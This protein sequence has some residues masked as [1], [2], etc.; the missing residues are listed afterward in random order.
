MHKGKSLVT[1]HK[2]HI[3]LIMSSFPEYDWLPWKFYL[4]PEVYWSEN[5]NRLKYMTWLYERL[6]LKSM[7]DW[8][9]VKRRVSIFF[10]FYFF[11]LLK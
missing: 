8:Y 4:T 5:E 2:S 1:I 7:E 10:F 11:I 9:T 3:S 6:G